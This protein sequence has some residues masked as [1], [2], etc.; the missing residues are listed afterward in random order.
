MG[1]PR[2]YETIFIAKPNLSPDDLKNLADKM[3]DIMVQGG[4][5]IVKFDEWGV[6]RLAYAVKKHNQ[7]F[8]F[9]TDYAGAPALVKELER[10]LKIDDR[11]IKYLTVKLED[12]LPAESL[13]AEA[14]E[15]KAK[16][17]PASVDNPPAE[18]AK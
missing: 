3:K 7:G 11:V 13:Q 5:Q 2:R 18:A 1:V 9:F 6:K 8:Y 12:A 14:E 4:G 16:E 17:E 15:E 10:N